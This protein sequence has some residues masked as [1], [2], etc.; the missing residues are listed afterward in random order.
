M[1]D[2]MDGDPLRDKWDRRHADA[3]GAAMP[4]EVLVDN[5]HLLP[6]AGD[7]LDLA[8]GLGGS[9]LFL[10]DRGFRVRAWDISPVAVQRLRERAAGL[11]LVAEARDVVARPPRAAAFDVVVVGHFLDRG[12][13]AALAAALRPGGL[14]FYQTFSS[15]R[16]D[17][18]GP[19]DG[20]YRL[21]PNELLR[22]FAGLRVRFYRDEGRAG[23]L[24]AG[25]RNRAQLVAQRAG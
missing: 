6:A 21:Q 10:A 24:A 23:D 22:L 3:S 9:A 4:L 8:C 20:P 16:V 13:C 17:D 12:L 1:L 14:L 2:R 19:G 25:F 11:P 15:E 18:S 7:A 5:A